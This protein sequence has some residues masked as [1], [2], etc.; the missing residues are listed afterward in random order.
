MTDLRPEFWTLP[1][2]KLTPAEWEALCDGCGRCC[3]NK[4]EY[5]DTGELEFTRVAC[6][7]L[8]DETCRCTRYETRHQYVPECVLLTPKS[9][10]KIAYW[11]PATC[12]YRLRFEGKPLE[13]WHYLISGSHETV[14]EAGV[15]V[16]GRTVS[17]TEVPEDL[18][19]QFII[20]EP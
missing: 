12:A 14:H 3:L 5:E 9:I 10:R 7:L 16:R 1:L 11:M 17:E 18:W 19:D 20:E 15:S 6:R 8:D 2:A 13:P 4:L